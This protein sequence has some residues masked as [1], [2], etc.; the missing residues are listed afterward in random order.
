MTSLRDS[1]HPYYATQGCYFVSG[2]LGRRDVFTGQYDGNT[3]H[4]NYASWTDFKAGTAMP[5]DAHTLESRRQAGIDDAKI[6]ED[7]KRWAESVGPSS[8]Y[9]A[10]KDYNLLYRWDWKV[11]DPDD[12]DEDDPM[13]RGDHLDLFYMLQRKARP[14][15]ATIYGVTLDDEPEIRAWLFEHWI[16][17]MRVWAPV[18]G[19][20]GITAPANEALEH[21]ACAMADASKAVRP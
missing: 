15:S 1:H 16:H 19:W 9:T 2:T 6:D 5:Y 21:V 8:M 11:P 20:P 3:C 4:V 13:P 10:D 12:E 18:S 17:M 7:A 14:L